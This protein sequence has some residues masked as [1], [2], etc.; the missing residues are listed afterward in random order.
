MELW[1]QVAKTDLPKLRRKSN[2]GVQ[3]MSICY[4]LGMCGNCGYAKGQEF[5]WQGKKAMRCYNCGNESLLDVP[6]Y[7]LTEDKFPLWSY[8]IP[9]VVFFS[10]SDYFAGQCP[11]QL[12]PPAYELEEKATSEGIG[13]A[14]V[15]LSFMLGLLFRGWL[16]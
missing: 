8:D 12:L 10:I 9:E 3:T 16:G 5:I 2:D 15:I 11:I 13:A 7:E 1:R 6:E 4:W 14:I